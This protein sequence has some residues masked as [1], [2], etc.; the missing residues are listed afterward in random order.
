MAATA[1]GCTPPA[2]LTADATQLQLHVAR[3]RCT[4]TLIISPEW[5][6]KGAGGEKH[7]QASLCSQNNTRNEARERGGLVPVLA[8]S[9]GSQFLP[10]KFDAT[11]IAGAGQEGTS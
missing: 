9:E 3:P 8:E 7:P 10:L 5:K 6:A 1:A 2:S 4:V 11:F